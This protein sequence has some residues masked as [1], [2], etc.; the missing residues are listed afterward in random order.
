MAGETTCLDLLMITKAWRCWN[1]I[2]ID[3][4]WRSGGKIKWNGRTLFVLNG[5]YNHEYWCLNNEL[6]I[7]AREFEGHLCFAL[8]VYKATAM[9]IFTST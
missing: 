3:G 4:T 5:L 9:C 7:V 1:I 6:L 2:A 8:A